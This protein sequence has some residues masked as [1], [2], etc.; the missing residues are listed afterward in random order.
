MS[1]L[2]SFGRRITV[3]IIWLGFTLYILWLAPL[4]R[5]ETFTLFR[6]LLTF[7]LDQVNSYL[8]AIFWMM[9]VW[10]M[11]YACLLFADG[12]MQKLPAFL[13]FFVSNGIGIVGLAPYLALRSRKPFFMGRM[14]WLLRSLDSHLMGLFLSFCTIVLL[15]YA[16][17]TGDWQ[18]FVEQWRTIPFVHLITLD[19][20]LMGLL[21]PLSPLLDDDMARHGLDR[22]QGF[23]AIALFPLI[24]ALAYL[25]LRPPLQVKEINAIRNTN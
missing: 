1:F 2:Q 7:E 14:D 13:Y 22:S 9:G 16:V 3:G 23:W 19:F 8:V 20:C 25:C 5:P 24:G 4:D 17:L 15:S 11:I 6:H 18:D 21:F 10:P 12:R